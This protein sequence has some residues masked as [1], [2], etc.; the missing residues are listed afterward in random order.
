M[1][2]KKK[3]EVG[4]VK[5]ELNFGSLTKLLMI[6]AI[7]FIFGFFGIRT[8]F[9]QLKNMTVQKSTKPKVLY[10]ENMNNL[11]LDPVLLKRKI[12]SNDSEYLLIDIRSRAEYQVGHIKGAVNNPIYGDPNQVYDSLIKKEDW[13]KKITKTI[14]EKKQAVI[15]GY[16]PNADI[17]LET[18]DYL[19]KFIPTKILA[20]SW[21]D[22]KNNFYQWTPGA[23]LGGVNMDRYIEPAINMAPLMPPGGIMIPP[24]PGQFPPGIMPGI[25][26]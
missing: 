19:K 21:H 24:G 15:Y 5:S 11:Y 12:D 17:T 22:W 13:W 3:I 7:A 6:L 25:G 4:I 9:N 10:K 1:K 8:A 18:A 26:P 23:D 20:V 2:K 16:S 14:K